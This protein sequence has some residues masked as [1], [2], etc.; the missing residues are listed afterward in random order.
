VPEDLGSYYRQQLKWSRGVHEV[1]FAELPHLWRRLTGQQ[2][3][4][5][6]TI[7]T[8]Y[9]CG[10]STALYLVF[11]YLYLWTGAQPANMRFAGFIL[12]VAPVGGIG[13]GIYL[14]VQR[15]FCDVRAERGLHW[16][17]LML[18]IACWPVYA[19]GMVLAI[20]RLDLPY[21]PTAK[22][23]MRGS[24][25]RLAWP[26]LALIA[27]YALTLAHVIVSRI[28]TERAEL[29]RSPEAIWGMA[30][31]ASLPVIASV[32]ALHAAWQSSR[33]REGDAWSA[34]DITRIG[35]AG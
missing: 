9:L 17:G 8:Y 12:A 34:I 4:A 14:F 35:D 33:P 20:A 19:T 26:H 23:A 25:V 28:L 32:V 3:L 15:W 24:F 11:P 31:F 18:K 27:V 22:R 7:G 21:V 30:L 2:R 10:F 13:A 1:L 5:Y 29:D 16:R 6:L